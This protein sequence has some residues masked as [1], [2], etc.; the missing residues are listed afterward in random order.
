MFIWKYKF[1]FK[2]LYNSSVNLFCN[3]VHTIPCIICFIQICFKL[4]KRIAAKS[5]LT[6]DSSDIHKPTMFICFNNE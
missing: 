4:S 6:L 5:R 3:P 1:K 2:T